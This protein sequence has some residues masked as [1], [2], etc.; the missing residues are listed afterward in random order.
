VTNAL[1]SPQ[2]LM[3]S[4][5]RYQISISQGSMFLQFHKVLVMSCPEVCVLNLLCTSVLTSHSVSFHTHPLT[6]ILL[7]P[8]S[9]VVTP[10]L[11][12]AAVALK[13]RAVSFPQGS[14][15]VS[16]PRRQCSQLLW[17]ASVLSTLG[18]VFLAHQMR[19]ALG[20]S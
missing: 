3:L 18:K 16:L 8:S 17:A 11:C 6:T 2:I 10:H 20:S 9:S 5:L 1:T 7:S 19:V 12:Q 14:R 15:C 13:T 4:T